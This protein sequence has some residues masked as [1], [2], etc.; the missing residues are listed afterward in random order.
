MDVAIISAKFGLL[1]QTTP[2]PFY[3]QRLTAA[4]ALSLAPR[5][6]E[7]LNELI[8]QGSYSRIGINLGRDYAS[9]IENLSILN[10]AQ[11]AAGS[12][13]VRAATLKS[14]LITGVNSKNAKTKCTVNDG[15]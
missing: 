13:G 2:I 11:W 9:M 15:E 4:R 8:R 7:D 5:L 12:I 6:R 10:S 1:D 14:W 3:D